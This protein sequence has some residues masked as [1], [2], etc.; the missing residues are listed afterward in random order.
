MDGSTQRH[1]FRMLEQEKIK[2]LARLSG[3]ELVCYNNVITG[4]IPK[5]NENLKFSYEKFKSSVGLDD[6]RLHWLTSPNS[7]IA[8]GAVLS[9]ILGKRNTADI[10]FFFSNYE[11]FTNLALIIKRYDFENFRS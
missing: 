10:D 11:S 3:L 2:T 7:V 8:G 9:W 1:R 5:P 4:V 6:L